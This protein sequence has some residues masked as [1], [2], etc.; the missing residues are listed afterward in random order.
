MY[1]VNPVT[2]IDTIVYYDGPQV[3]EARNEN[4]EH[5]IAWAIES[6]NNQVTYATVEVDVSRLKQYREGLISLRDLIVHRS[7]PDWYIIQTSNLHEPLV[8]QQM[9]SN[10]VDSGFLPD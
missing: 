5:Y 7:I 8:L 10:L 3:F 2:Y 9:Q 4:G 1:P 6:E